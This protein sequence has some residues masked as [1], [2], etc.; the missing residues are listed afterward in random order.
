MTE[1]Y[2]AIWNLGLN[3]LSKADTYRSVKAVI[4]FEKYLHSVKNNK[5]RIA[6]SR[7]RLSSH[8]L[9]IQK[10]RHRKPSL[11]R[12]ERKCPYCK[13][14]VENE[15]HFVISCPLYSLERE[16]LFKSVIRNFTSFKDIPSDNQKFFFVLTNE[17]PALLSELALFVHRA[18]KIRTQYL[19]SLR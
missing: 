6:L 15:C 19:Y 14:H 9:L 1:S 18:F 5:H 7:L 16:N 8:P 10:G 2:D 17:D 12:S 3:A 11:P 4:S 13:D